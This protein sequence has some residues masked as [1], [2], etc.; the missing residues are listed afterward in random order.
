MIYGGRKTRSFV[1]GSVSEL[2]LEDD[3][4]LPSTNCL[5]EMKDWYESIC[6]CSGVC[7]LKKKSAG[8]GNRW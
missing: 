5:A 4:T 2:L 6:Y 7:N 8:A 3:P 1:F